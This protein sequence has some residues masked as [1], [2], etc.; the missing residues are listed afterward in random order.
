[1]KIIGTILVIIFL[2][3]FGQTILE[4]IAWKTFWSMLGY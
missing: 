2:W 1:M 4:A 3:Y